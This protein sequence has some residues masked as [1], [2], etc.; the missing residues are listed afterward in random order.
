MPRSGGGANLCYNV[1]QTKMLECRVKA[2]I[3]EVD[4]SG[5]PESSL[6]RMCLH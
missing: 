6:G 5:C 1:K 4:R 2:E 3:G